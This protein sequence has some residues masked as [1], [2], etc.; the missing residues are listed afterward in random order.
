MKDL[1]IWGS[2]EIDQM[3]WEEWW[4]YFLFLSSVSPI[5]HRFPTPLSHLLL[6]LRLRE[7]LF[8]LQQ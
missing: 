5:Q 6:Y 4:S 7:S 1:L 8:S 3:L 2:I